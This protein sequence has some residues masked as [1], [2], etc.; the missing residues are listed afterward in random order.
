MGGLLAA[1]AATDLSNNPDQ[2]PGA[3]PKRIVGMIAFDTPYLGM[4]PHVV[5]SGLASLL[6]KGNGEENPQKQKTTKAMNDHPKVKIVDERVT[7]DWE[8]FKKQS[9]SECFGISY[10]NKRDQL[11][12]QYIFVL[13]LHCLRHILLRCH[14]LNLLHL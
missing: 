3:K 14:Y 12:S 9:H 8:E 10:Y 5:I 2:H 13:P 11:F 7:D 4:H 6:P 1:E